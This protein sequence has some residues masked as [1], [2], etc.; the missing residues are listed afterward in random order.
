MPTSLSCCLYRFFI[1]RHT[2]LSYILLKPLPSEKTEG[3]RSHTHSLTHTDSHAQTDSHTHTPGEMT[4]LGNRADEWTRLLRSSRGGAGFGLQAAP[5]PSPSP[6]IQTLRSTEET[7]KTKHI[8]RFHFKTP[9]L[10]KEQRVPFLNINRSTLGFVA[11]PQ[12]RRAPNPLFPLFF[13]SFPQL[14]AAG[15]KHPPCLGKRDRE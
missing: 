4:P 12:A 6:P 8:K 10:W 14:F 9:G 2:S 7:E 15:R 13:P 1:F 3:G 5:Y 11:R